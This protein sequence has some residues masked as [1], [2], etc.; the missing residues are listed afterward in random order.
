MIGRV[1]SISCP[2]WPILGAM[3]PFSKAGEFC[4]NCEAKSWEWGW[5]AAL[6]KSEVRACCMDLKLC[7]AATACENAAAA[8]GFS[9][10]PPLGPPVVSGV[11]G[12]LC[13]DSAVAVSDPSSSPLLLF[14]SLLC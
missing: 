11:M 5:W 1:K 4:R 9:N 13:P 14:W 8:E 6:T 7:M 2:F 3:D 10:L 12:G